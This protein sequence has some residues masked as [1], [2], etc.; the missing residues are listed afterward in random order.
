MLP[1]QFFMI[2]R[3]GGNV[4]PG[5]EGLF[6]KLEPHP[7]GGA[8]NYY[9]HTSS[10]RDGNEQVKCHNFPLENRRIVTELQKY[11]KKGTN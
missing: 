5:L 11:F 9:I 7:P 10:L 4:M 8:N 2:A 1:G 6:E 3:Q